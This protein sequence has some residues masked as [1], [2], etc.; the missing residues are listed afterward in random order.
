M[1]ACNSTPVY[2]E[3]IPQKQADLPSCRWMVRLALAARVR[4]RIWAWELAKEL[5]GR[6]QGGGPRLPWLGAQRARICPRDPAWRGPTAAL[7]S[8][9]SQP[10]PEPKR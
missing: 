2:G 10:G 7:L 9:R 5:D 6:D 3:K 1:L 4:S 8:G